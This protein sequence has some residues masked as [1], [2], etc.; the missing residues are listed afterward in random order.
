MSW[1]TSELRVRL[2]HR[3]TGLSPPVKYFTDCSN[4]VLLLWIFYVFLSCVYYAFVCVCLYVTCGHLLGKGWRLGSRLWCLD[5]SLLIS[6]W[7]PGSGVVLDCIDSW[8]LHPYFVLARDTSYVESFNNVKNIFQ[9]K[10]ISFTDQQYYA[11]SQLAVL[12]WKE[13]V[14]RGLTSVYN[15]PPP[16]T[17]EIQKEK[18]EKKNYEVL[19]FV[20]VL[21][22]YVPGQQLWSCCDAQLPNHTFSWASLNKQ[23]TSTSCTHFG[24]NWQQPFL[25]DSAEGRRMTVEIIS[26]SISTKV[27]DR[28]GIKLAT[29]GSVVL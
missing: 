21:L 25:N 29:T 17:R 8:S 7:Y 18:S 10:W 27:W 23:L 9:D 1:S 5:S 12:H 16:E 13:N 2:V 4:A 15:P 20:F 22:R 19:F 26:W 24:L 6:S 14:D 11:R 3:K 28:T